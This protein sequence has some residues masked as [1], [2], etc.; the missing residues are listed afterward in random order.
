MGNEQLTAKYISPSSSS[1]GELFS[2]H[3]PACPETPSTEQ[4]TAHLSGLRANILK[5]Q[6]QVNVFLTQ[7]MD[8]QKAAAA[9][10]TREQEEEENYGEEMIDG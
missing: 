6:S 1:S 4:R 5:L 10:T 8:D 7:K 9:A 3:L 2:H